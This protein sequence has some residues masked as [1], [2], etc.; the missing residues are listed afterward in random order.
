VL[1]P[2]NDLVRDGRRALRKL[3]QLIGDVGSDRP[4][5]ERDRREHCDPSERSTKPVREL[6]S[7]CEERRGR[8][9]QERQEDTG[10]QDERH[11]GRDR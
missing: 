9:N 2:V 1:E 5:A 3:T 8:P 7:T 4:R 10:E 6:R 11:L